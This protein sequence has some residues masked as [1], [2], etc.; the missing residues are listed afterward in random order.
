MEKLKLSEAEFL[1]EQ[2]T[3]E[4]PRM[5]SYKTGIVL[6]VKYPCHVWKHIPG[7]DTC[8]CTCT[9]CHKMGLI[10]SYPIEALQV[11][12]NMFSYRMG[13]FCWLAIL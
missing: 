4:C 13:L 6:L 2:S 5:F 8:T 10:M 1:R 11:P 12:T 3:Y 7:Y 9:V